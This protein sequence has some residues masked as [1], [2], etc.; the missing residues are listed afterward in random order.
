MV[1]S[2][3]LAVRAAREKARALGYNPLI[4]SSFVEGETRE[5]ARVHAAIAKGD[6]QAPGTLFHAPACIISG[7]ETTVT[8]RGRG[9]GREE[10]GVRSGLCPGDRRAGQVSDPE[11]GNRRHRWPHRCGG[12]VAEGKRWTG[13]DLGLDAE[14]YLGENDSYHFFKPLDDLII[15][16]PTLTN[17]MDLRLVMVE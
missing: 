14:A 6:P 5:V 3:A 10:S 4:L 16:G 13:G 9:K 2:N 7:G 8:I 15:T 17:V 11:R 1:G 12:A